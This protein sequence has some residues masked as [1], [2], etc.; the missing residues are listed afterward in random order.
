[1]TSVR[2]LSRLSG[3]ELIALTRNLLADMAERH[4]LER[5]LPQSKLLI[6]ILFV[7]C[8]LITLTFY[9]SFQ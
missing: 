9:S 3:K 5:G 8:V 2:A 7:L 4:N 1:M 6:L